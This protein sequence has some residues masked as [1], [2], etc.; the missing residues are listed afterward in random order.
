M[1]RIARHLEV[2]NASTS[3]ERDFA[4]WDDVSGERELY[5]DQTRLGFDGRTQTV[6]LSE[7]ERLLELFEQKV[8]AGIDRALELSGRI[9]PTYFTY[10][11]EDYK[12]IVDEQGNP[13]LDSER[14]PFIQAKR[15]K[16]AALPLFLGGPPRF[17]K[18]QSG[19]AVARRPYEQVKANE[20]FDR[21][22]KMYKVNGFLENQPHE[23][24]CAL[25]LRGGWRTSP[26]GCTW[27]SNTC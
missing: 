8:K 16:P 22:L 18:I 23:I 26:S 15:F 7:L 11:V 19:P 9:P 17:F 10:Q 4:Y 12:T 14:R 6:Q 25:S 5:R 20:L 27:N 13:K 24:G 21:K 3:R 2:Y 1:M